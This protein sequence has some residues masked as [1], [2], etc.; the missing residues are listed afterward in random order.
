LKQISIDIVRFL[1]Y[2]YN[3]MKYLNLKTLTNFIITL[4][5]VSLLLSGCNGSGDGSS[6]SSEVSSEVS[7]SMQEFTPEIALELLNRDKLLTEIFVCNSLCGDAP[8]KAVSVALDKEN[9]YA[10][11][12]K[13]KAL[14]SSTYSADGGNISYF[15]SYPSAEYP[16]VSE[17]DGKTYVFN[18]V[19]SSYSDYVDVKTAKIFNGDSDTEKLIKGKSLSGKDVQLKVVYENGKW[20]LEK[21]IFMLNPQEASKPSA[22]SCGNIGSLKSLSG[23]ILVI[24]F[25]ISDK[26]T[27]F[28][29][30]EETAFH[31]KI[32]SSFDLIGSQAN[33]LGGNVE[34]IYDNQYFQHDGVLGDAAIDFDI[35]FAETGFGSLKAFAEN[36]YELSEYDGY[37]FVVCQ[38]KNVNDS[39]NRYENTVSTEFYYGE[40]I[41]MGNNTDEAN[42]PMYLL[43]LSGMATYNGDDYID[44][45]YKVYFPNDYAVCAD[46]S[47]ATMSKV[48]A[49]ACGVISDLEPLYQPFIK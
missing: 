47:K 46:I 43:Q 27:Q 32:K 16:S 22:F 19:G 11:F 9:E 2:N 31:N 38:N 4:T 36:N 49:F 34:F 15:L 41:F 45:L 29:S 5:T 7:E 6:S 33:A 40:R 35:V 24:E 21:G 26:E 14:L 17:K 28:S 3:D 48:T 10:S 39:C 25:F 13:I 23:K 44:S 30:E 37:L 8:D 20:L 42:L 1:C 18:H 12:S